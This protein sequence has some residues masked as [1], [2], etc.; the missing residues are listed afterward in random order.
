MMAVMVMCQCAG[1]KQKFNLTMGSFELS[2]GSLAEKMTEAS[3]ASSR[4]NK[5]LLSKRRSKA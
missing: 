5:F 4:G 2:I 1:H 3:N